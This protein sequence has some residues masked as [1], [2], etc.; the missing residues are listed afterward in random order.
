MAQPSADEKKTVDAPRPVADLEPVGGVRVE[1]AGEAHE[2]VRGDEVGRYIILDA[3]ASGGMGTVYAAYDPQLHRKVAIKVVLPHV[4]DGGSEGRSRLLREAQALAQVTHPNVV[5]IHDV[6]EVG[7]N[8]YLAMEL[9]EG[10]TLTRWVSEKRPWRRVVDVFMD[11]G[12]GLMAAHERGLVHRDFKPDN[13]MIDATG[14]VRVMDFG[15]ARASGVRPEPQPGMLAT[16]LGATLPEATPLTSQVTRAGVLVGTPAYMAPEQ[17][18]RA[19]SDAR[20]DQFSF[21]VALWEA[22]YGDRPFAGERLTELCFAVSEGE[23]LDPPRDTVVPARMRQ[24]LTRGLSPAA[25]DRWPSMQAL[26]AALAP[27]PESRGGV[28]A[29][30]TLGLVSIVGVGGLAAYPSHEAC[31][32]GEAELASVWS[33]ARAETIEAALIAT[34]APFASAVWTRQRARVE[35]YAADWIASHTDACQTSTVRGEQSQETME[36]RMACLR[37]ARVSLDEALVV[38]E[39]ADRAVVG[40]SHKLLEGLRPVA[41]C[42]DVD[43]L[44]DGVA[45]PADHERVAAEDVLAD[46]AR[47]RAEMR[48]GRYAVALE[49]ATEART[50]AEAQAYEP[51]LTEA[52]LAHGAAQWVVGQDELAAPTLTTAMQMAVRLGQWNDATMAAT[53]LMYVLGVVQSRHDEAFRVGDM[54]TGLAAQA[55]TAEAKFALHRRLGD[56]AADDG[57]Y[58]RAVAEYGLALDVLADAKEP[59]TSAVASV[60]TTLSVALRRMGRLDEAVEQER[61]ALEIRREAFGPEHPSVAASLSSL[62][63]LLREQGEYTGGEALLRDALAMQHRTL[64]VGSGGAV[65]T[66]LSLAALLSDKG[67][68]EGAADEFEVVLDRWGE[69]YG[70]AHPRTATARLNAA[71][72][73]VRSGEYA[74]AEA[75]YRRA[76]DD[77]AASVGPD[78]ER[79][80]YAAMNLGATL[81]SLGRPDEGAVELQAAIAALTRIHGPNH[82]AVATARGKL[83]VTLQAS[84][85]LDAAETEL[86][87]ALRIIRADLD[88]DHPSV[89]TRSLQLGGLLLETGR[90]EEARPLLERGWGVRARTGS[91]R[92]RAVAAFLLARAL[93]ADESSRARARELAA[94]ALT[95]Y[96]EGHSPDDAT[97]AAAIRAWQAERR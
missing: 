70:P 65:M 46:V 78:H 63:D 42:N 25:E 71:G 40:R 49:I 57:Q 75:M 28:G 87:D 55:G 1:I 89:A 5:A 51:A 18:A 47:S 91:A 43:A 2:Y 21:C 84:G 80:A 7:D 77:L 44:R 32:G 79:T 39:N 10:S 20:T 34:D 64:G 26:V 86:R 41:A 90:I 61:R 6:G 11:A 83:G 30:L 94:T 3:L 37:R 15:L 67:D 92:S 48:A 58:E 12:R 13:V 4:A 36:R 54:A 31:T 68:L 60:L 93:W 33:P 35:R 85:K 69:Q 50:K 23:L 19:G 74:T 53:R 66:R 59:E 45:L 81:N 9:V 38:L 82:G 14:R 52:I 62:G 95:V 97:E 29:L 8:V 72:V 22:L 73:H 88:D 96:E 17:F 24:V 76:R 16:E 27:A 56:V